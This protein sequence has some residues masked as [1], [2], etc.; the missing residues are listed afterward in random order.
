MTD[1]IVTE[2][3]EL[4]LYQAA[5]K[6]KTCCGDSYITI[7]KDEYALL[8]LADGLG[9]GEQA[10]DSSSVVTSII[11]DYH[12]ED[13]HSLLKRCN[14]SLRHKRG[15]AVAIAKIYYRTQEIVYACVGNI[16]FLTITPSGKLNYPLPKVGYLSGKPQTFLIQRFNYVPNSVFL[17]NTDG[18]RSYSSKDIIRYQF[19]IQNMIE[20][21][22]SLNTFEDDAT[23]LVGKFKQ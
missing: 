21:F 22:E 12:D 19:G 1:E 11:A 16:R 6:G 4:Y 18:I 15:A 3:L 17:M 14:N 9:S 23:V 10:K 20:E 13:V 2:H 7:M 8:A 5:K